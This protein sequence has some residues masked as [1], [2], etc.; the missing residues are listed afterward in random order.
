MSITIKEVQEEFKKLVIGNPTLPIK[1]FV[2]EDAWCGE[3]AYN[4]AHIQNVEIKEIVQ[5][6]NEYVDYED[7]E[8]KLYSIFDYDLNTGLRRSEE[9]INKIINELF[10]KEKP[11]KTICVYIN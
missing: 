5:Y 9:E 8:D 11:T 6:K 10:E 7:F 2:G 4:E 3:W 1:F